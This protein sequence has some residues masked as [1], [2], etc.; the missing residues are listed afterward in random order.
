[1]ALFNMQNNLTCWLR[2]LHSLFDTYVFA[3]DNGAFLQLESFCVYEIEVGQSQREIKKTKQ[4][5]FGF[6]NRESSDKFMQTAYILVTT[7]CKESGAKSPKLKGKTWL[8]WYF[9]MTIGEWVDSKIC[10]LQNCFVKSIMDCWCCEISTN[11]AP[12]KFCVELTFI[13]QNRYVSF[14]LLTCSLCG[15]FRCSFV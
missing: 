2:E 10:T 1:M 11:Y 4:N 9:K 6:S 12:V 3:D 5:L 15:I 8:Q 13:Q 14:Y 7:E